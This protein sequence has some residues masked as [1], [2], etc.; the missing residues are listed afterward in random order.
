MSNCKSDKTKKSVKLDKFLTFKR[1][2]DSGEMRRNE[3]CRALEISEYMYKN[4]S[5]E[6]ENYTQ[7][8]SEMKLS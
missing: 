3:A 7:F 4:W 2:V 1:L 6:C 5:K 8:N